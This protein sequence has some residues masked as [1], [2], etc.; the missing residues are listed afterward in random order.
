MLASEFWPVNCIKIG[1]HVARLS[2]HTV[3]SLYCADT[4]YFVHN[5]E[6]VISTNNMHFGFI[7][8]YF[9]PETRPK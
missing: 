3:Y 9:L 5:K 8:V 2:D 4:G 7:L 6:K 1:G